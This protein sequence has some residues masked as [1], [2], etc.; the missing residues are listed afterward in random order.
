MVQEISAKLQ[1]IKEYL[2]KMEL[3]NDKTKHEKERNL[4]YDDLN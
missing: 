4:F 1:E 2:L 3:I